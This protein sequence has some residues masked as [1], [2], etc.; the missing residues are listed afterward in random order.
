M[1]SY[2]MYKPTKCWLAN[3]M[4]ADTYT[5]TSIVASP[6]TVIETARFRDVKNRASDKR[7]HH[8]YDCHYQ[9]PLF[10]ILFPPSLWASAM[11][12]GSKGLNWRG[13]E[14]LQMWFSN[15]NVITFFQYH[16]L[17]AAFLSKKLLILYHRQ[18]NC[19]LRHNKKHGVISI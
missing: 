10:G 9:D 16:K 3:K 7:L 4:H 5:W 6:L 1:Y 17:F 11:A 15:A 8:K 2:I 12:D 18:Y 19:Q 13:P 14:R